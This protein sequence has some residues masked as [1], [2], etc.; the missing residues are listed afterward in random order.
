MCQRYAN[1]INIT[2]SVRTT[3]SL[4]SVGFMKCF[5]KVVQTQVIGLYFPAIYGILM[6]FPP[7]P[8]FLLGCPPDLTLCQNLLITTFHLFLLKIQSFVRSNCSSF[9]TTG[10]NSTQSVRVTAFKILFLHWNEIKTDVPLQKQSA[11][12]QEQFVDIYHL[13]KPSTTSTQNRVFA[14]L[15]LCCLDLQE[16]R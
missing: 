15:K 11:E 13:S 9:M 14:Q 1:K 10:L 6:R 5:Q 2:N 7:Q 16:K 4:G 8:P 12:V 3:S